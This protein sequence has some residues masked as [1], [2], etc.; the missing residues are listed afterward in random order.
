MLLEGKIAIITGAGPG[1]GVT[2]ARLMREEG[3]RV[4]TAAR[5]PLPGRRTRALRRPRQLRGPRLDRQ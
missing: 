1:L 5:T 4:V 3:A 2:L